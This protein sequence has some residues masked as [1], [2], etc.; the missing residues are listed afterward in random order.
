MS[1]FYIQSRL[2]RTTFGDYRGRYLTFDRVYQNQS[3]LES[4]IASVEAGIR[5]AVQLG[6][7]PYRS[8]SIYRFNLK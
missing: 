2:F 8:I 6:I 5:D 1:R 3:L 4:R 7:V